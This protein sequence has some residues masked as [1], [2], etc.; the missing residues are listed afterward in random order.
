MLKG[1]KV[2]IEGEKLIREFLSQFD[3]KSTPF[4]LMLVEL[5]GRMEVL[6][7][8]NPKQWEK[9]FGSESTKSTCRL[10]E[11]LPPA[12]RK[13]KAMELPDGRTISKEQIY[14]DFADFL[15]ANP[16]LA[17]K[18]AIPSIIAKEKS[19]FFRRRESKLDSFEGVVSFWL[20]IFHDFLRDKYR[21]GE[22][23]P[24]EWFFT[25]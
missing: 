22:E 8:Q 16:D 17:L 25:K 1:G 13:L 3:D 24:R 19:S 6:K 14:S 20:I 12:F 18:R 10:I 7:E 23:T 11:G 21:I 2:T 4:S 15:L 9:T 5:K